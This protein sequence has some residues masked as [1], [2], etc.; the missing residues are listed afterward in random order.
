MC[1]HRVC[2]GRGLRTS[3]DRC[4]RFPYSPERPTRANSIGAGPHC[5]R[6]TDPETA[7]TIERLVL[8]FSG[9][10]IV[11]SVLLGKLPSHPNWYALAAFLGADLAQASVTGYCPIARAFRK[12][13]MRFGAAFHD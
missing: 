9:T 8:A 7:V 11:V 6:M 12:I 1:A 2:S 13:G 3:H 4:R 5:S 10:L